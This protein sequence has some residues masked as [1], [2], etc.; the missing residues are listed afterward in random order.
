MSYQLG[1]GN[2]SGIKCLSSKAEV[3]LKKLLLLLLEQA[4]IQAAEQ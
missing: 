1:A 2:E 4:L 3:V